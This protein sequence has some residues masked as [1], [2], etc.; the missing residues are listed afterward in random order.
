MTVLFTDSIKVQLLACTDGKHRLLE[1]LYEYIFLKPFF[2]N[3]HL[4]ICLLILERKEG[5]RGDR[6]RRTEGEREREKHQWVASCTRPDQGSNPR[7]FCT[8]AGTGGHANQL[9]HPARALF[10]ISSPQEENMTLRI[11]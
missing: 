5:G 2:L 11:F 6:E 8:P 7:P 9:R 3:P 10:I 4:R 1:L